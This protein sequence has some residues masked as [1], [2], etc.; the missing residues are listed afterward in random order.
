MTASE[1]KVL[2]V[3]YAIE[4]ANPELAYVVSLK[5]KCP[6]EHPSCRR[7]SKCIV[8]FHDNDPVFF[9]SGNNFRFV[10]R[11]HPEETRIVFGGTYAKLLRRFEQNNPPKF[12]LEITDQK[13]LYLYGDRLF[14]VEPDRIGVMVLDQNDIDFHMRDQNA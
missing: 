3:D 10:V 5:D 7:C 4:V 6:K 9:K 14:I 8:E 13:Y 11:G 1:Y 12:N 2:H